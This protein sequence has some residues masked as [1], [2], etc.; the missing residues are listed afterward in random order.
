MWQ[1]AM[2][3]VHLMC[4]EYLTA[5]GCL[6]PEALSIFERGATPTR[7]ARSGIIVHACSQW[8]VICHIFQ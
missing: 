6:I 3:E 7:P 5:E 2:T 4:E 8:I 1:N